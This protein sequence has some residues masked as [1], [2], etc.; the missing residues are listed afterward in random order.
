MIRKL[1]TISV[2][3]F[4]MNAICQEKFVSHVWKG[5]NGDG[6]YRNPII[7]ADYSDPDV[8]RNGNDYW[9]TASSFDCVPGLPILHSTDLV[10]WELVNHALPQL[11]PDSVFSK[12]QRGNGVWAPSIRFHNGE[13]YIYWGDPDRGL[14][15]VKAKE[16]RGEWSKPILVKKAVGL[17]DCCPLWDN[18]GKAYL[19]Y[20][21]AGS[22]AGVKSILGMCSMTADGTKALNDDRIIFDGHKTQPTVEGTKLYKRGSYYY[23][24]SPAGGVATGWQLALR[25][26]E[27]W[28][29]YDEKIVMNQGKTKVNGPHQGAW[30]DTESGEDWFIHFQDVGAC[31]RIL[32]LQPMKWTKNEWPVIGNDKDGDGCGE[33]VIRHKKPNTKSSD[34]ATPPDD[35]EFSNN[36]IGLQWQWH[37][38]PGLTW[39]FADKQNGMLRLFS[40]HTEGA[41]NL[42]EKNNILAQKTPAKDF[43]ATTK[44]SV[45]PD[46]RYKG[47]RFSYVILGDDY[48][49]LTIENTDDGLVLQQRECRKA[50]KG[51]AEIINESVKL[52]QNEVTL[53][54]KMSDGERCDFEYSP[55][56]KE[57]K[58]IGKT[59][60]AKEGR[61]IGAKIGYVAERPKKSNDGGWMDVDWIRFRD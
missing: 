3:A 19:S 28:G 21:Y 41:R 27:I 47:E 45:T 44:I 49:T 17:I 2:L 12:P 8:C 61:W 10:N 9:M 4:T 6:T 57:F 48:A 24:L 39:A 43:K 52:K 7:Y 60:T 35:D 33:P 46:K 29:P 34:L 16:P 25:S 40:Q 54:I 15:M 32:H 56:G 13:F 51:T 37:G 36:K 55:D 11:E 20:G 53:R 14:Y 50:R 59:F 1:L 23:I 38:N 42:S 31:G 22:R 5:D 26:K 18:D 30:V 58:T